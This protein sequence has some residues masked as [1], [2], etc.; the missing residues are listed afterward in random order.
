MSLPTN[1]IKCKFCSWMTRKY[2]MGSTPEKAFSKL[3]RHI[4]ACHPQQADMLDEM[5]E[6][7]EKNDRLREELERINGVQ[8]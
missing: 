7:L 1:V 8:S 6:A 3:Y 5:R 4:D 2:G